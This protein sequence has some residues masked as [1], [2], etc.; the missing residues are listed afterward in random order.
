MD[1]LLGV[2][3]GWLWEDFRSTGIKGKLRRLEGWIEE[4]NRNVG[5]R[6][7]VRIVQLRRT[8]YMTLDFVI[9]DPQVRVVGTGGGGTRGE[10]ENASTVAP[11]S[12][13]GGGGGG[14]YR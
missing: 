3:T 11:A 5:G 6:D 1:G 10:N 14:G 9:P 8:G 2:V 7:G 12:S 4:W 13:V